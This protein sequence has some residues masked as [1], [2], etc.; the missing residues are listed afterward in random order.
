MWAAVLFD[1]D[2]TLVD[3]HGAARSAVV[4]WA[5]DRGLDD[6]E[7]RL[8][9]RW[10]ALSDRHYRR[11]QD[12]ELTYLEQRR[13]RIREFLPEV[14]LDSDDEAD[15][16]FAEHLAR[17][18]EAWQA[19]PDAAPALRRARLAGATIAVLTNGDHDHQSLKLTR[20]G[21]AD[22]VDHLVAT[23]RLAASKPHPSAFLDACAVAGSPPDRTLMI[24][25]SLELDVRGA[26]AAGL[27]AVWLDRS[28]TGR[29]SGVTRVSSLDQVLRD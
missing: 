17:Y 10:T 24:G 14:P 12:R 29:G 11:Y 3:Q 20:T 28:G 2:D 15:A 4:G 18:E 25:D 5:R 26:L 13:V 1:L 22:E 21:L 16:T 7:D 9:E 6:P 23:S 8:V 19:F 27:E